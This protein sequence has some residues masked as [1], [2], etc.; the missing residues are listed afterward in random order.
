[1]AGHCVFNPGTAKTSYSVHRL[2][3]LRGSEAL[4]PRQTEQAPGSP[5]AELRLVVESKDSPG[6]AVRHR[7]R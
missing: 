5:R 4:R 3:G 2:G 1:M 7:Q 6:V